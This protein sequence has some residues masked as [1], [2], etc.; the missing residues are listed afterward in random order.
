M[1]NL[2]HALFAL[3]LVLTLG[4]ATAYAQALLVQYPLQTRLTNVTAERVLR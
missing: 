4:G 3:F 2:H 1:R